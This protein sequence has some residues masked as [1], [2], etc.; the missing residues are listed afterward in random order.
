M[1]VCY[2]CVYLRIKIRIY[3]RK[4]HFFFEKYKMYEQTQTLFHNNSQAMY[5]YLS[6]VYGKGKI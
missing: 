3:Q 5:R 1:R 2:I 6:D 4:R